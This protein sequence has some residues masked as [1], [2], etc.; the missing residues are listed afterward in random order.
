MNTVPT[1]VLPT[2]DTG[3][4]H[5]TDRGGNVRP[6]ELAALLRQCIKMRSL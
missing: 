6:F 2:Q 5:R 3:P 4:A 1:S